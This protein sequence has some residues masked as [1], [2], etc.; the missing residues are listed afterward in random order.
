MRKAVWSRASPGC[1]RA[2]EVGEQAFRHGHRFGLVGDDDVDHTVGL[3]HADRADLVGVDIAEPAAGDHRRPA[4]SERGVLGGDDQIRTARDHGV[5]REAAALD[6]RDA[7][8]Q[9]R[10][11]GPE[12]ERAGVECG[13]RGIVGVARSSA[14]TLG[15][16]HGRQAH[17]FDQ[18]EEAVLLAVAERALGACEHRVVVGQDGTGG[19]V[20]A[21][22]VAVD[23]RR[24]RH[25][26]VARGAGDQVGKVAAVA[27]GGDREASVLD[28]RIRVDEIG[29]VLPG[30]AAVAGAPAFDRVGP[31]RVLGQRPAL[32][33]LCVVGTDRLIRHG[34]GC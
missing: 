17:A 14:A 20:V 15:E 18:L 28:E 8:N 34:V 27:L 21:E 24:A 31:G 7:R 4:H 10:Q 5:A 1:G 2:L 19:V 9:P 3:L 30:G 26:P 6:D 25:Q 11:R 32:Q 13:D 16:E 23:A 33:Q 22:E 29:D 12:L